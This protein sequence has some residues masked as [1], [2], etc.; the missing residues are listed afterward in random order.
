[1][2]QGWA[3]T[4]IAAVE[5]TVEWILRQVQDLIPQIRAAQESA[6]TANQ[7]YPTPAAS[8]GG[9]C[10]Y[11]RPSAI[12]AGATGTWPALTP[13]SF[14]AD[15]YQANGGSI[16]LIAAGASCWN[17]MPAALVASQVVFLAFDGAASY[18][19]VSQSCV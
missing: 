16:S 19:T 13:S 7:Q 17:F 4:R 6:R 14:I 2:S 15:V 11:C 12:V 5:R 1:M 8:S 18:N 9:G 10:F 3:E